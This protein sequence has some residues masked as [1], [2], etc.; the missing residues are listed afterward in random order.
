MKS[1]KVI[2]TVLFGCLIMF[3]II[4]AVSYS[5]AASVT[6]GTVSN[7]GS[8][9]TPSQT[10]KLKAISRMIIQRVPKGKIIEAWRQ[11]LTENPQINREAAR[12]VI[13]TEIRNLRNDSVQ[14][15]ID[16]L[17][18][19]QS[20]N[21]GELKKVKDCLSKAT[22]KTQIKIYSIVNG[23]IVLQEE[24]SIAQEKDRAEAEKVLME[25]RKATEAEK[26]SLDN[27]LE[28]ESEKDSQ[29]L[30]STVKEESAPVGKTPPSGKGLPND[31]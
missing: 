6:K 20:M 19:Y 12:S 1:T 30:A 10:L 17:T 2:T 16:L 4:G 29:L 3:F 23:N 7:P 13:A 31:I 27:E 5:N 15:R 9:F 18:R 26:E 21:D 25:H 24:L 8:Q 22:L 14:K 11:F 28:Q